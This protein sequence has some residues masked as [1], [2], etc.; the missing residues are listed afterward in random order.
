MNK[1]KDYYKNMRF[2]RSIEKIQAM[3]I[4]RFH[5]NESPCIMTSLIL[6]L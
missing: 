5:V 4:F 1:M 3:D 2:S 6:I